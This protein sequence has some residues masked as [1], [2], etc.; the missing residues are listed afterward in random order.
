MLRLNTNYIQTLYKAFC[1]RHN[2]LL[3]VVTLAL[4]FLSG[5]LDEKQPMGVSTHPENWSVAGSAD[6]HGTAILT[7]SFSQESCQ[8]CHG[9]SYD[10]GSSKVSCYSAGCH[11]VYPHPGGFADGSSESFHSKFIAEELKWDINSCQSCHGSDYAGEG[12]PEKNCLSCHSAPDGPENCS[13]CH[14]DANSAAPPKDLS[15]NTSTSVVTVG[16]HQAHLNGSKWSTFQAGNCFTCHNQTLVYNTA[17]HID[18]SPHSE[19]VFNNLASSVGT[20]ATTWERMDASCSNVYCHGGFEFKKADSEYPWAYTEDAM[21]GNNP[22]M[23]WNAVGTGQALCGSCHGLP[24][25]GHIPAAT[26]EGCHSSV[27]D[28]NFNIINKYLHINGKIDVY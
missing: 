16:A 21:R 8:S 14:G 11:A 7:K 2:G 3:V 12:T 9:E 5:C 17:G 4:F 28:A 18:D 24:P 15:G 10:G 19:V 13:S 27:V 22:R 23:I 26:C 25:Q 6:F 20:D 1:N